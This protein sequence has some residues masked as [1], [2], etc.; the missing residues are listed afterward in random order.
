MQE[1]RVRSLG[2]EDPLEEEMAIHSSILG[3]RIHGILMDRGA[4]WATVHGVAKESNM[5]EQVN[6]NNNW[7]E[8]LVKCQLEV[9]SHRSL[10]LVMVECGSQCQ[11]QSQ[12]KRFSL[13]SNNFSFN[14]FHS[15]HRALIFYRKTWAVNKD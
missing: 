1:T 10:L 3:W 8:S 4:W 9:M 6:N 7:P 5:T 13:L 11:A 15:K 14:S 12:M 2:Q